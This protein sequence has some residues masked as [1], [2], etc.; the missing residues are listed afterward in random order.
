MLA[1]GMKVMKANALVKRAGRRTG[2]L[3]SFPTSGNGGHFIN[4]RGTL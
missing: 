4:Q 2:D 3:E 1:F